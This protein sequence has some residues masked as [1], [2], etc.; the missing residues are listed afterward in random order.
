M[1]L[2]NPA[3]FVIRK[4]GFA[5]SILP[6]KSLQRQIDSGGLR[7]L[8]EWCAAAG[9]AEYKEFS[10]P[11]RQPHFCC[12]CGMINPGKDCHP[13]RANL[14]FQSVHCLLWT[15]PACNSRQSFDVTHDIL[16]AVVD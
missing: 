4:P 15:E 7:C 1:T 13:F 8:H 6:D 10:W 3:G 11:Q 16:V 14:C 9:V 12:P 5:R 2:N